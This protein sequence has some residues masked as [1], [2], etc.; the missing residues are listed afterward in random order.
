MKKWLILFMMM[1]L[2]IP[3]QTALGQG[4]VS[5]AS[6]EVDLWPEYDSPEML[7]I[8]R[9]A[10]SSDVVLPV[11]LTIEIPAAAGLPNAV[12][13]Q[14][15]NG[16][17]L[18]TP[19]EREVN[20]EWATI[21]LTASMTEIQLE[22]YDPTLIKDGAQRNYTFTWRGD[23]PTSALQV[24]F[25][26]PF[27]ASQV[28]LLPQVVTIDPSTDGLTHYTIELGP[29]AAGSDAT[30]SI[31]YNK[32]SDVL[33]ADQF[34]VQPSSPISVDTSG[35]VN[36]MDILPWALAALGLILVIGGLWWYL[37]TE[38]E[39][40]KT[41]YHSRGQRTSQTYPSEGA[42]PSLAGGDSGVYCHQCG[43]R[44]EAGDRFCRSCGTKLR[45]S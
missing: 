44:A 43:K 29:Q 25:L 12:A 45:V 14:D 17:L 8:Y 26:Q 38:R 11:D 33:T 16:A 35:R 31:A 18:N 22:Y 19:Y 23:Y 15:P 2:L 27:G 36:I 10:L 21:S 1:A 37:Q 7:V 5:F 42:E 34:Q 3:T 13:V 41:T 4:E 30:V 40:P 9:I 6:V 20:G 24:K 28:E 32:E 39:K